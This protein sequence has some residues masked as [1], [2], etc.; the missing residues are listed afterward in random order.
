MVIY[1][2]KSSDFRKDIIDELGLNEVASDGKMTATAS[3][4]RQQSHGIHTFPFT[5]ERKLVIA[6]TVTR[7]VKLREVFDQAAT[8]Q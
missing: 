1:G 2:L 4:D 6:E 5:Q 8:S 7:L 3:N